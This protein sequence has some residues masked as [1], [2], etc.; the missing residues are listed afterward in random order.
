M[1]NVNEHV[2]DEDEAGERLDNWLKGKAPEYSRTRVQKL[3]G[4]GKV[5][6]NGKTAA[7]AS[8]RLRTGDRV[9]VEEEPSF[10][11]GESVCKEDIG[12][13][14]LYEDEH[15]IAID[16]PKG[17]TVHPAAGVS[18]GTLVNALLW[19]CEGSLSDINGVVRPGIVHRLDRDTSGVIIA[20]KSNKAHLELSKSFSERKIKKE[21][22]AIVCGNVKNTHG[23]IDLPI[24][25]DP[26]NRKRMAVL[27]QGGRQAI[28]LFEVQERLESYT[29]LK[30]GLVT[31]RTHQIRVHMAYIGHPV[32]GDFV[33]GPGQKKLMSSQMLHST[34]IELIHP[35]SGELMR[36]ES[37]LPEYY[38]DALSRL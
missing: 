17:M 19:H 29:W 25:R 36:I 18:S 23:R 32:A 4:D 2:C 37:P 7:V 22:N 14:V 28:T 6:L 15:M 26:N 12:L 11:L 34:A 24:G 38:T 33:Y 35:I 16:K 31:G 5:L 3:I 9:F 21:Y 13:I 30:I 10:M 27:R 20:A 8:Y 1:A